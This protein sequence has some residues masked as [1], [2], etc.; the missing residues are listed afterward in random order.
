MSGLLCGFKKFLKLREDKLSPEAKIRVAD[1]LESLGKEWESGRSERFNNV[2]DAN[3]N[4]FETFEWLWNKYTHKELDFDQNPANLKDIRKFELGL[5]YYNKLI[6]KKDGPLWAKFHLPRAAMRNVPELKRFE[7]ELVNETQFFREYNITTGRQIN[8][9]LT[10]FK[11]FGL[12]L[13]NTF[14]S[15]PL[16]RQ[17][18]SAGQKKVSALQKEMEFITQKMSTATNPTELANLGQQNK[19]V[20][21]QWKQLFESGAPRAFQILNSVLQGADIETVTYRD[22]A[23]PS[24]QIKLD[25]SQKS[26]LYKIV[27]NMNGVRASGVSGLIRGL[28]KIKQMT[29]DKNLEWGE[30]TIEKINSMIKAIEFQARI[31]KA[32]K[33]INYKDMQDEQMFFKLGFKPEDGK[34]DKGVKYGAGDGKVAFNKH[35]MMK[36]TLGLLQDVIKPIEQAASDGKLTLDKE[37][38]ESMNNWDGI[39]DRAKLGSDIMDIRY[40]GDPYFFLKK[41]V[42]D[43]GTFNYKAHV[44]STFKNATDTI[45][46]EHLE[47]AREAKREDLEESSMSMLK[48]IDDVYREI[49]HKDPKHEG[50]FT[51]AMRLMTSLTYFRLMGGNVRSA[52]RNA[53]QRAYE[54]VQ[55]GFKAALWDAPKFYRESG[56]ADSNMIKYVRQLKRFGLQWYDGKSKASNAWD[57][58]K[59]PDIKISEGSRGALEDAHLM[60]KHLFV[61]KNGELQIKGEERI[62]EPLARGITNITKKAGIM[63]KIVEDWNRSNT[64]KVGFALAHTNLENSDKGWMAR[65]I[66][67]NDIDKIKQKKGEDHVVSYDDVI[68]KYGADH[69][70]QVSQWIE[71]T[72]GQVAH[73]AVLDLHFEYS[74]WAKAK[75]IRVS[76]TESA[77]VQF[78]KAGLGQ[79]SHYRF[80]MFDLMMKWTRE[81]AM[82]M[83]AG[84]F[85][86]EESFRMMRFGMLQALVVGA[87]IG[88]RVNIMKLMPNDVIESGNAMFWW[89][90]ANKEKLEKGEV[91]KETQK[92]LD[93]VTY[94][95][96]GGYFLGPNYPILD[97]LLNTFEI[98]EHLN[99]Q[100]PRANMGGNTSAW[101]GQIFDKSVTKAVKKDANQEL[102]EKLYWI[103]S[104]AARTAAYTRNMLTGGGGVMDAISLEFGL[105]PSKWQRQWSNWLYGKNRKGRKKKYVTQTMSESD[106]QATLLALSKLRSGL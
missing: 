36:Y 105:F 81:G 103:N 80:N 18:S 101:S 38:K 1:K 43:V 40:D 23:N 56:A 98:T 15:I 59:D 69:T 11:D 14:E 41:Y 31:D 82:S 25:A 68:E 61:D 35:Y 24:T 102:Y 32:G 65:K 93:E 26:S 37:I 92:R 100:D 96:G 6:A 62:T 28:Q 79:F 21:A 85:T 55:F 71:S 42:N 8:E 19:N 64:F 89:M 5:D 90:A 7:T 70:K 66:L 3:W 72:A 52:A 20:Q 94:G 104:Q 27:K 60:D 51:D 91:T 2:R 88:G 17:L 76:G 50:T 84:D 87:T 30:Q 45:T 48:L 12:S 53:T 9:F 39:I 99:A 46:K 4:N 74:K 78:A 33:V 63:H 95:A 13:G 54:W 75:A 58:I 86:S 67:V 57:A 16:V 77:A 44:K 47:P 106:R 73:N 10:E 83:R 34:Y 49:Q 22:P 29:I 97:K